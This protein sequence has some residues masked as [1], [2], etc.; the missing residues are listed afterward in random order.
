MKLICYDSTTEQQIDT[1]N[2]YYFESHRRGTYCIL[3]NRKLS[4]DHSLLD[5]SNILMDYGFVR[6]SKWCVVNI[7][8][9]RDIQPL[10]N[11]QLELTMDNDDRI[12]VNRHYIK[13]FK[14]YLKKEELKW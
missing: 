3:M 11:S 1:R 8:L 4:I 7:F 10:F 14:N 6:V 13:A 12:Y 5:L 9:I 2:I